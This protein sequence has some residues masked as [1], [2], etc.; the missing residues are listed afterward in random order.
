[1][2]R[3]CGGVEALVPFLDPDSVFNTLVPVYAFWLREDH[4]G[5]ELGRQMSFPSSD[6]ARCIGAPGGWFLRFWTAS[7]APM[8]RGSRCSTPRTG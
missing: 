1:M 4:K 7:P 2:D 6:G 3:G 8:A 5:G